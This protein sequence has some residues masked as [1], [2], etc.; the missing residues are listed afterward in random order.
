MFRLAIFMDGGYLD[1]VLLNESAGAKISYDR[2]AE[3]VA[4]LIRPDIDLLRT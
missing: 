2:F 3:E 4:S 1:A